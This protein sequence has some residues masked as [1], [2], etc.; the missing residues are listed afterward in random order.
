MKSLKKPLLKKLNAK[1]CNG[2]K[3]GFKV[4]VTTGLTVSLIILFLTGR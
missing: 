3:K 4:L 1:W 2:K